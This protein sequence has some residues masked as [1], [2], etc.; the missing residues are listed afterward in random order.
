MPLMTTDTGDARMLRKTDFRCPWE[1]QAKREGK[2]QSQGGRV[3]TNHIYQIKGARD[4]PTCPESRE[5]CFSLLGPGRQLHNPFL[6]PER[7]K[8]KLTA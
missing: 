1:T 3:N 7:N 5:K 2:G 4:G 6:T 8:N